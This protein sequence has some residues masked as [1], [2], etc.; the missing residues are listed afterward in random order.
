[1]SSEGI[2]QIDRDKKLLRKTAKEL[3]AQA[4]RQAPNA[5]ELIIEQVLTH[6][7]LSQKKIVSVFWPLPGELD[8]RPLLVHLDSLG[9]R[10]VL[11][12]LL[13]AGQ[14]LIFRQWQP[15]DK[16]CEAG[17]GTLEPAPDK[18][19]LDPDILLVPLLAFDRAGYRLGYGGGFYDRTLARLRGAS[20]PKGP[21]AAGLA[22]AGQ[23]VDKVPREPTDQPLNRMITEGEAIRFS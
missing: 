16:L 14:P 13:G 12:V 23:E 22:F 3:R 15:G 4:A 20:G 17:F 18:A 9:H 21:I 2:S 19:E 1:M 11:P 6:L 7:P 5:G 10:V 8:T